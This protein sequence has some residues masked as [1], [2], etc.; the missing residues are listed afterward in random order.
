MKIT[1]EEVRRIAGLAHLD[2]PDDELRRLAGDLDRILQYVDQLAR[3]DVGEVEPAAAVSTE[4]PKPRE[5]RL[6]PCLT[7]E[8]ALANAPKSGRGHFRVPRVIG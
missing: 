1:L 5:D 4:G 7:Q 3:L 6:L 2:F 8:Q